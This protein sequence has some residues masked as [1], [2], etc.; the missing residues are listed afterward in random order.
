MTLQHAEGFPPVYDSNSRVLILGSFPSV[1]SRETAFYYG[2]RQNRFWRTVCG[3]FGEEV[4]ADNEGKRNFLLR[5]N[6]ALWD[7]II[8]CEIEGSA[9]A[10]IRN[11]V[12]ADIP[13]VLGN[14]GICAVICNGNKAYSLFAERFPQYLSITKKL[15]STSPANP[16][17]SAEEWIKTLSELF[18]NAS[19]RICT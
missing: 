2:N 16:R 12:V 1:K 5:R 18:P 13:S 7:V 15:S 6:I 19:L 10:S 11:E 8:E 4:P 17:F 3:F 14:S 9:D